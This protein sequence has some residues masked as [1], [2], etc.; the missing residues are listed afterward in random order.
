MYC[1]NQDQ[2]SPLGNDV[3]PDQTAHHCLIKLFGAY[4]L[5]VMLV[6]SCFDLFCLFSFKFILDV[7]Y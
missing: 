4:D 6:F 2:T 5:S 7:L 1:I 3:S